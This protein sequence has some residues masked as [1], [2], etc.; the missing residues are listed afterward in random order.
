MKGTTK[1]INIH[2]SARIAMGIKARIAPFHFHAKGIKMTA[3]KQPA[4]LRPV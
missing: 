2:L 1:I 3:D 4:A